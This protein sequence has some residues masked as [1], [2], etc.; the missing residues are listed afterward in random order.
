M[1]ANLAAL[2]TIRTI[3][4]EDRPAT[5]D[6]QAVLAHW[7]GW[8]AVPQVF[9]PT[10]PRYATFE[11]ARAELAE[12]LSAEEL[13]AATRNTLNAHYTDAAYVQAIWAGVTQL[14]FSGG[15]VLEPGCGSGNFL[16]LAPDGLDV[17]LVGVE[18]EPVTAAIAQALYPHA[19][20]RAES[21]ADTRLPEAAFDLA[22]GNVPFGDFSLADPRHN[23]AQHS[24][25]NHF[26]IKGLH[27]VRPG[28]L[29]AVLTSRYT[30][31]RQHPAARREIAGLADLVGAVRLPTRAHAEAAGTDVVTDLLILRRREP[32]RAPDP[33]DWEQVRPLEV[34]DSP[35]PIPVNGYFH[36]HPEQ[37]LGTWAVNTGRRHELEVRTGG[38]IA[39]A[40]ADA[41]GRIAERAHA[42]GLTLGPRTG[43]TP[44]PIALVGP[45]D[46]HD[47][48][49]AWTG[50][51]FTQVLD[52]AP[53][54]YPVPSSQ[55]AE[56]RALLELRN[57]VTALLAT[58]ATS[59]DDT[60][61]L[62]ELRADLN[63]RYD[64][65][66]R[67]Y[68]PINRFTWRRTGRYDPGTGEERMARVRPPQGGFRA[69][70]LSA[71]VY[72]LEHFD[73]ESM[74]ATKAD[75]FRGRVIAP[76]APRLGADTPAD[77]L[78]ICLDTH[79]EV[80]LGEVARLLG[81]PPEQA[82]QDL[83]TLVFDDPGEPGRLIPAAE[84]LS[85]NVR[86]KL[87]AAEIAAAGDPRFAT[88]VE[89]LRGVL[90]AD[91]GP[92]EID[93]RLGAAWIGHSYVQAFLRELLDDP[94]LVVEHPG[95][96]IWAVRGDRHSVL[97]TQT[98][99][100][101]RVPAPRLA[102]VL[103]EQRQIKVY[104]EVD[105]RLVFN[106][107]ETIAAQEKAKELTERFAEWVWA[108]PVR[109]RELTGAYNRLFNAIVLRS[110]DGAE[111]SL[112]GLAASFQPRAHQLAAVARIIHEPAVLLAHDVGAGKAQPMDALILTPA[113]YRRMGDLMVGDEV[114]TVDGSATPIVGVYPQG[115]RD[116][117]RVTFS[118][119]AVVECNDQ[120]LWQVTTS[121][122]KAK[123]IS[124]KVLS[125][126]GLLGRGLRT[127]KGNPRWEVPVAAAADLDCGEPRPIDPYLLGVLIGDGNLTS[128]HVRF[129]SADEELLAEVRSLLPEG[130]TLEPA[131]S[132]RPHDYRITHG[133]GV[134]RGGS[135]LVAWLYELG[136]MGMNA[137]HKHVPRAYLEA[138]VDARIALLQGLMDTDG[139][140]AANRPGC[141]ATLT[142]ASRRLA[143]DVAWLVR[144]LGGVANPRPRSVKGSSTTFYVVTVSLPPG[145][146][147]FRLA[148]KAKHVTPR[149]KYPVR[150][151][152]VNVELVG[153][154]PMQCIAVAHPSRLYVT[155][156]FVV[157]HN[158]A[159]MIMGA[160]ELRRLGLARKPAIAVP[161]HM[162]EQVRN[163]W[164]QLYPQA[165]LLLAT[166]DDLRAE[167]RRQFI[168]RCATGDWDAVVM[169]HS[170]FERIPMRPQ[171][172]RAYLDKET[173]RLKQWIQ[174]SEDA[175]STLTVKR[176]ERALLRAEERLKKHLASAKDTGVSFEQTGIDYL[177][178]DEAHLLK[179]LRTASNIQDANIEGSHRASDAEMKIDYLRQQ[180]GRRV[181]TFA[182]ATPIAN[183]ITEAHVMQRYLRPDILDAAGVGDFD[184]WAATFGEIVY[185]IELAPAGG[186][187]RM[188]DRLARFHNLPELFKM[189]RVSAD[190]KTA[191]DLKLPTPPLAG[192]GVET[193]VVE[194]SA[195]LL[196]YIPELAE[197]ADK[198]RTREVHPSEDNMLKISTDGRL[199]ALDLRLIGKTAQAPQKVDAIAA[200]VAQLWA[201]HRDDIYPTLDGSSDDPIRGS[202]QLVFC[203]LGT[204]NERGGWSVYE[205]LRSQLVAHGIP[206][207][208]I[209]FIHDATNDQQKAE[210]FAAAR[211]GRIATLV[212]ST[213]KMGIGTNVQRRAVAL[214]NGDCPWRPAD[215]A[216]RRGRIER[217]GNLTP[218]IHILNY[219]TEKS[220]DGYLW[221]TVERKARFIAQMMRGDLDVRSAEDIGEFALSAQEVKALA[222]GD[223]RLL[224]RAQAESELARLERL[225]RA[226]RRNK[227]TLAR[228][229]DQAE[230]RIPRLENT[231]VEIAA[232]IA[233]RQPT[234]GK[235]FRMTVDGRTFDSRP[236]AGTR[237]QAAI[238]RE[239]AARGPSGQRYAGDVAS[240][241]GFSVTLTIRPTDFGPEVYL[242]LADVPDGS[243]RLDQRDL[244]QTS[245]VGL[246]TRLENRLTGLEQL[247]D[248][249][250]A[251][252]D[253]ARSELDRARDAL[254]QPFTHT[255][256]LAAARAHLDQLTR[257]LEEQATPAPEP[258]SS[259]P[260]D[261][262]PAPAPAHTAAAAPAPSQP[263]AT[264]LA[265]R[266]IPPASQAAP[267]PAPPDAP[268]VPAAPTHQGPASP[269]PALATPTVAAAAPAE[270][271][272]ITHT[273][274]DTLVRGTDREDLD[275]RKLLKANRFTWS[276]NQQFWYLP[277]PWAYERRSSHVRG[278]LEGLRE[279]GRPIHIEDGQP[280]PRHEQLTQARD[281]VRQ[282]AEERGS[283]ASE[284]DDSTAAGQ[285]ATL[286]H[287][288]E[289]N[290]QPAETHEDQAGLSASVTDLTNTDPGDEG[291][292]AGSMSND[293]I[294][295]THWG[296]FEDPDA[297][298]RCAAELTNLDFLCGVDFSQTLDDT[299]VLR[300]VRDIPIGDGMTARRDLV[301]AIVVGHGGVYDGGESGWLDLHTDDHARRAGSDL[302]ID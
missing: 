96:A 270:Q 129:S 107:T 144:S 211:A 298:Q 56:L 183:S 163:E 91:L 23:Q 284:R 254:G 93:V 79:G 159:E 215:L 205:E 19:R 40:L 60:D 112:P 100:T 73:P 223:P 250:Q 49:L 181:V 185:E 297:A 278:L 115:P 15:R 44:E 146:G 63:R 216:Q 2:R 140:I 109:A 276:R 82:R 117:Y 81:V 10:S 69:D 14:G 61:E 87:E 287:T 28:G 12:L 206:H 251:D 198:V 161:N 1:R 292:R 119:G 266:A 127:S 187:F 99:G 233:R 122:W 125:L 207:Q 80:R 20:I 118:D 302:G 41:I 25:H 4:A 199:A 293:T 155:S 237:L 57:T 219:V 34:A 236:D 173:A 179:N 299:W 279:L 39:P 88:N 262:H 171:A 78:A 258:T 153:R 224:Q 151:A 116:N 134:T 228:N 90:P 231:I 261:D 267:T 113:G 295:S 239:L 31:D 213:S 55:A 85:G 217:Q 300:A 128:G 160:M 38:Q 98:W 123:G 247:Q 103:L 186:G 230:R 202:L 294:P 268:P 152:I 86:V 135:Q 194:P 32:D 296:Y 64:R 65:Y 176:M 131:N 45:I 6:E 132:G 203:D 35:A 282:L 68:G 197:R 210:L 95:G 106:P 241:G 167:R 84:Y 253:R 142:T 133:L 145:I 164:L 150:R 248:R 97:A 54:P 111:L 101:V 291:R 29:V 218:E 76:R 244:Q 24:I 156:D 158:T 42:D 72:A 243:V 154:K 22:I 67:V 121:D 138:P 9:D 196:A 11:W 59:R 192:G 170:T 48:H 168:A 165:R 143:H 50:S 208:E 148:R 46:A 175:G 240:L 62:A 104:D 5:G 162:L 227:D 36:D 255:D 94:M 242:D 285:T 126:A 139:T 273:H 110:Y 222:T 188:K 184:R 252:L 17:E 214:H 174:A 172:Q 190:V 147:P 204:P 281:H 52:G 108:D 212:G 286:E 124:P 102:E 26:I 221:Q 271:I 209:R 301:K 246:V 277:R 16:G 58:E 257:E 53:H 66:L 130:Y 149:S 177:F 200:R 33:V 18:L 290:E 275:V 21:F 283:V 259:P 238:A 77:A 37:V 193:V 27:L 182:T 220:F 43:H 178:Y 234:S 3:Q 189:W 70:P 274:E 265:A 195:E 201:A 71:V 8:G 269:P 74:Q 235:A 92:D 263:T 105:E 289:A 272:R 30:M 75:V 166:K 280:S 120:H 249:T 256:A 264:A 169:T 136:L 141:A 260:G 191:E 7:S 47:G 157:T 180:N 288:P 225:E 232:A 245:P 226:W 51:R 83:G 137:H 114:I 229:I 89:T 13:A